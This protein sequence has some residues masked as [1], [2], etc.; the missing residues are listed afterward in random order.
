M[1]TFISATAELTSYGLLLTA[2]TPFGPW[3]V[4]IGAGLLVF[5]FIAPRLMDRVVIPLVALCS[6]GG[7]GKRALALRA[8][9]AG[10][11]PP[12]T[13]KKLRKKPG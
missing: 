11:E 13:T 9:S 7:P 5:A 1:H 10:V 2:L 4:T 12:P 3:V 6:S 8:L